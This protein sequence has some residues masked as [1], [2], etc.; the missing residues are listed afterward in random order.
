MHHSRLGSRVGLTIDQQ[1]P[2]HERLNLRHTQRVEVLQQ[3]LV[4]L[5]Q[6]GQLGVDVLQPVVQLLRFSGSGVQRQRL[7]EV[8]GQTDAVDQLPALLAALHAVCVGNGL[9]QTVLTQAFVDVHHL[10]H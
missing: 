10:L 5:V 1:Q 8:A 7:G 6:Y 2:V 4:A 9:Q 3:A